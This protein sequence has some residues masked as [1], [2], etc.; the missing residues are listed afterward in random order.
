MRYSETSI[1]LKKILGKQ[2][3]KITERIKIDQ[4]EG[5]FFNTNLKQK[6]N[7][8]PLKIAVDCMT[9]KDAEI[10]GYYYAYDIGFSKEMIG[11]NEA[12][13]EFK[14]CY[15]SNTLPR[16]IAIINTEDLEV[17]IILRMLI[18]QIMVVSLIEFPVCI[19]ILIIIL[20]TAYTWIM[21]T[22]IKMKVYSSKIYLAKRIAEM[23]F[24]W[25]F[26]VQLAI[27]AIV[28]LLQQIDTPKTL[29]QTGI[30]MIYIG[31][32]LELFFLIY[33]AMA[34]L[35]WSI[36]GGKYYASQIKPNRYNWVKIARFEDEDPALT[37]RASSD[38]RVR[39]F[40]GSSR[41]I[42]KNRLTKEKKDKGLSKFKTVGLSRIRVANKWNQ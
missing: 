41:K 38:T 32:G 11:C 3:S 2:I 33:L 21:A 22:A 27:I 35:V 15:L 16:K 7:H 8:L 20:E 31:F 42:E 13:S 9:P 23:I 5:I 1:N 26:L 18:Y 30:W 12:I 40:Y 10:L 24:F 19:I 39:C 6:I 36:K 28:N 25:V 14:Y 4:Q 34:N 29:Q 17:F 37:L